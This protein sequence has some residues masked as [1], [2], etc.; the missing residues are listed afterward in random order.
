MQTPL[1]LPLPSPEGCGQLLFARRGNGEGETQGGTHG[2]GGPSSTLRKRAATLSWLVFSPHFLSQFNS[3][4][5]RLNPAASTTQWR[6]WKHDDERGLHIPRKTRVRPDP[7]PTTRE[8]NGG[9]SPAFDHTYMV[10]TA[11]TTR[12]SEF[13]PAMVRQ[14]QRIKR[15]DGL[16]RNN[17]DSSLLSTCLPIQSQIERGHSTLTTMIGNFVRKE[18]H[19]PPRWLGEEGG[20]EDTERRVRVLRRRRGC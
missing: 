18:E 4:L 20:N 16:K 13:N 10:D 7:T 11:H 15:N 5:M 3:P 12:N 1:H 6:G 19:V 9:F 2:V 17:S 8:T 14:I